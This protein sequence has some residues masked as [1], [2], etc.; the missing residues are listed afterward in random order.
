MAIR[1]PE[2]VFSLID[3]YVR[4]KMQAYNTPSVSLAVT[5]RQGL[6]W[7][8]TYGFAELNSKTAVRPETLFEIG[9]IGK[10]FTAIA[11]LQL[12]E[13]GKLDLQAPITR[14]LPWFQV[15]SAYEPI[16]VHHLL[17]HTSGLIF[18]TDFSPDGRYEAW[19]L[20]E[21]KTGAPP[22][23]YFH[24]SN[25]GYKILGQLL[26]TLT[27]RTYAENIRTRILD[28]LGMHVSSPIISHETRRNMAVGYCS[29]YD[30]RPEHPSHP[31]V[32]ATWLQ[33]NTGD[34]CIASTAGELALYLRMLM[35][36]GVG[37]GG[38]LISPESYNLLTQ[39][40][41]KV[42]GRPENFYGYGL[43][44]FEENGEAHLGHS[45]GMVG[46]AAQMQAN[47]D[48]GVGLVLLCSTPYPEDVESYLLKL[49]GAAAHDQEL[50]ALPPA[51]DPTQILKAS[52]FAGVYQCGEKT[53]RLEAEAGQLLLKYGKQGIPLEQRDN[54]IFYVNHPEWD[55]Y[56]LRFGRTSAG[57]N[58]DDQDPVVEAFHGPDWYVH[59]R[60]CGE[61]AFAYPS[62]W[63]AYPGHYST[64][65]PWE[66]NLRVVLRKGRLF[67]IRSTGEEEVL[68]HLEGGKFRIGEDTRSPERLVFD[69]VLNGQ[70]LRVNY[71]GCVYYRFFSA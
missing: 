59:K 15:R 37:P 17:T 57:T 22:G 29:L 40:A 28:P 32:P 48:T 58:S 2:T 46:Y 65:N 41:I 8:S 35:N 69:S 10:S 18:G 47:L 30:D 14:Y 63:E 7:E 11:L 51:S 13:A 21:T 16:T 33:T 42:E 55:R 70:A 62:E 52:E 39:K 45:G 66:T 44:T 50:P 23:T 43:F 54:D 4:Q 68:I 61:T 53:I 60:Y 5:D 56:L 3:E 1:E 49:L 34:G 12:V 20:R 25:I 27:G 6:L 24:Y 38:P 64:H 31:L 36:R 71:S 26:E 9:S 19:A 67:L